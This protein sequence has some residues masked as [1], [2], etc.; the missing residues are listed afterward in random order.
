MEIRIASYEDCRS[1]AL[2]KRIV[3]ET[4]YRGIYP[5]EKIDKYDVDLNEN[6][7]K[8]MIKEQSQRLFVILSDSKIIGY[9]SCGKIMGAF[10]KHTHD[11]GLLYLLKEYQGKGIG[12]Q[13]FEFA[14]KELKNQG[15]TEFIVSCNKYNIPA[16]QFYKK[17]GGQII[18]IDED[19]ED[20]SIPQVK[21]QFIE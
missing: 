21:F 4:T 13:M 5:D 17:M 2:L 10:D 11:I 14:K 18:K 3:W 9:I 15:I 8:N 7:F 19:N 1:L 16:Q 12:R 6:K 20:K